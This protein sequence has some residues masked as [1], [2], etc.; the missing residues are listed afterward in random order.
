MR[1]V[2]VDAMDVTTAVAADTGP[3]VA[4][5]PTVLIVE[6]DAAFA[7]AL[8]AAFESGGWSVRRAGE[9]G[10]AL[11]EIAWQRPQLIVLDL[12]LPPVP[13]GRLLEV[14]RR[15][16]VTRSV[17]VVALATLSYHEAQDAVRAGADDCLIK[18]LPPDE[19]VDAAHTL[20]DRVA[21]WTGRTDSAA[22]R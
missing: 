8:A 12:D 3:K 1:G 21:A 22:R 5:A 9:G 10:A 15:E 7:A 19:V 6:R 2:N 18:P 11:E 4:V 20:L 17:P 13:G 14:L 16:P